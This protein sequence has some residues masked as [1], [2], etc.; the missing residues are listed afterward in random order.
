MMY[1]SYLGLW[2]GKGSRERATLAV[3]T[4]VLAVL[5]VAFERNLAFA[6]A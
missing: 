3:M 5:V 1:D 4:V 6:G 2:S